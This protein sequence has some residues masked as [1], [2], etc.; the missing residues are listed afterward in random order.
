MIRIINFIIILLT[1]GMV[2]IIEVDYSND[3][4]TNIEELGERS[5]YDVFS[6]DYKTTD[7]VNLNNQSL[8]DVFV[9]GNKIVNPDLLLDV[10]TNGRADGWAFAPTTDIVYTLTDG[11]QRIQN[12]RLTNE[13][14]SQRSTFDNHTI[15]VNDVI[16]YV[17]K[18]NYNLQ[19]FQI[20]NNGSVLVRGSTIGTDR[21]SGRFVS[22]IV[23][24]S[25]WMYPTINSGQYAELDYFYMYNMTDL[26]ISSLTV[27]DMD[28]YYDAFISEDIL[29]EAFNDYNDLSFTQQ[30]LDDYYDLY[31]SSQELEPYERFE[32]TTNVLDISDLIIIM[33]W[34]IGYYLS[35]KLIKK[36]LKK[37]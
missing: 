29:L 11:I 16:Y 26:G 34:L 7:I 12:N 17:A 1:W 33:V 10:D 24:L 20:Y 27:S 2:E 15:Q 9:I 8:N 18:M 21:V 32:T 23:S 25:L 28:D 37:L 30:Q 6:V 31:V 3:I 13:F 5:L 35:F 19:S 36:G 4:H 22:T 14:T